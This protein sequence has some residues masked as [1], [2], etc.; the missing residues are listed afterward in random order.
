MPRKLSMVV[1]V[2]ALPWLAVFVFSSTAP[3]V[4]LHY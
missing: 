2:L 3:V 4:Y 1:A